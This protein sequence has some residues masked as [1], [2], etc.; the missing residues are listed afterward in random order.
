MGGALSPQPFV[1]QAS[2]IRSAAIAA[3]YGSLVTGTPAWEELR[4]VTQVLP[5]ARVNAAFERELRTP[6]P[7]TA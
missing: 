1:D 7:H 6:V 3:L 2:R 5:A 4:N